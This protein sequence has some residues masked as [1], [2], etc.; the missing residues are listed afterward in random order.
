MPHHTDD[1]NES[2]GTTEVGRTQTSIE[3]LLY[4]SFADDKT[5][6]GPTA[7]T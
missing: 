3:G 1:T 6:S 2:E 4:K 7:K 5:K